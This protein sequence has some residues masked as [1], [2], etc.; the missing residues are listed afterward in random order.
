[1]VQRVLPPDWREHL[2]SFAA[3]EKIATRKASGQVLAALSPRL[4]E[5]LGGSADLTPSNNTKAPDMSDFSPEN[6][7]G[8]YLHYG[9]REHA[10]G[11]IINGLVLHGGYRPYGGTFLVFSDY[12]RGAVRLAALMGIPAV[13]VWTHDSIAIGE[14]G[15]THQPVEH[16]MSLRAMPGLWVIRPADATETAVAWRMALERAG[17]PTA[18]I[19]T[20]QGLPVLDR[21]KY[22]PAEEALKGGYVLSEPE[23]PPQG[24][25]V[26][27]G[28]EVAL[29]L[30][31]QQALAAEGRPV[32]VVS[33]PCFKAFEEQPELYRQAVLPPQLPR[34]AIEAGA[35]LGWERYADAVIGV[36]RFGASAPGP[37][38]YREY[39]FTVEN[40][41]AR[42]KELLEG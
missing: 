30:E 10:M 2:P 7:T 13:Y 36:D 31:A 32:R 34:L 14:D 27:T 18:L 4:P 28:S 26:A 3:G 29:A 15:P 39:G 16:L 17:G 9:V 6:P 40:V 24:V 19:L 12:M 22:A 35:T 41:V 11:A 38:V 1:M 8:R 23:Q 5:L 37:V 21:E 42:M 20:R 25:L 33:L